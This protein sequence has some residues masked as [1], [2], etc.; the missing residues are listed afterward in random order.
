MLQA[1][2][3]A[4]IM[5]PDLL[6]HHNHKYILLSKFRIDNS[7]GCFGLYI[8]LSGCNYLVSIKYIIQSERKLK[9]NELLRLFTA[10]KGVLVEE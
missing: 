5:I 1:V 9:S 3:T 4:L 7:E 10:S 8:Q 6:Q 2:K